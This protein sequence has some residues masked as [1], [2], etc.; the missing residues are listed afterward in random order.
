[1]TGNANLPWLFQ[2]RSSCPHNP[3]VFQRRAISELTIS[4]PRP[5]RAP[6]KNKK[7]DLG[8]A[9]FHKQATHNR[10]EKRKR[11]DGPPSV[12]D[13]NVFGQL[14]HFNHATYTRQHQKI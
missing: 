12:S 8:V 5:P 14:T 3:F 2:L 9:S 10:V 6:L 4:I 7:K 1:M 13:L 11:G